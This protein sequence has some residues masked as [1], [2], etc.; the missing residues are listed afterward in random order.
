MK[1]IQVDIVGLSATPTGPS[2]YA[3]ILK[4]VGG[5]RRLPI[6][7]GSFEAQ[8]I[9]LE[10][11]G[12]KPPRPL[13]HDLIKNIL[14]GL[15][16][17][18]LEV[19]VTDLRDGTFYAKIYLELNG[20]TYE[21]DSRPSDA[22]AIALRCGVPIYVNDEVMEEASFAPEEESQIEEEAEEE[23]ENPLAPSEDI[24]QPPTP[25]RTPKPT[26]KEE[27]IAELQRQLEEA[28]KK[29]EYEK[30]AKIRDEI[31]RLKMGD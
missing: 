31:R 18:I 11:E 20:M 3:L 22:I 27:R 1:K 12:I 10:M 14:D 21:I 26:S 13:T 23:E 2:S 30:A 28:I 24:S 19:V 6:I 25:K 15:G 9:A 5:D 17:N 16:V 7:I 29:E 8:A 4:E